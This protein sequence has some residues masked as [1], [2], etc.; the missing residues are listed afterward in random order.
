[1]LNFLNQTCPIFWK[2]LT[3]YIRINQCRHFI[4]A[5]EKS[6]WEKMKNLEVLEFFDAARADGRITNAGFSLHGDKDTFKEIVDAYDWEFGQIQY[7][8]LDQQN[9]SGTEG[10]KFAAAKNIGVIIMEPLRGGNLAGK[11]APAIQAVWDEGLPNVRW[12]NGRYAGYG[13]TPRSRWC[14]PA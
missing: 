14:C 1:M 6:S 11:I 8:F 10:L 9:Q 4:I 3:R 13:T 12:S 5:L 7:N 2:R